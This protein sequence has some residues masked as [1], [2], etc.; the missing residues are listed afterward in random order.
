[1]FNL[2]VRHSDAQ[3]L[4]N[5]RFVTTV[6]LENIPQFGIQ[7]WYVLT[8]GEDTFSTFVFIGKSE[9]MGVSFR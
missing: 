3:K 1:M 9:W 2:S 4:K 7:L 8:S 5:Y 6:L